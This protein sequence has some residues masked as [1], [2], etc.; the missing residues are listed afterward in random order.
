M[1]E[2]CTKVMFR[3]AGKVQGGVMTE[4]WYEGIWL[5]KSAL[6]DE[7]LILK[8]DGLVV[9]SRAVREMSSGIAWDDIKDIKST[10]HDPTLAP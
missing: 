6:S 10:P 4:R 9:R 5:G 2:F 8:K 7:H 1:L 3:V